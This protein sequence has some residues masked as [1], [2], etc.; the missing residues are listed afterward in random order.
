[1]PNIEYFRTDN[2]LNIYIKEKDK[3]IMI[4]RV[5]KV[6]PSPKGKIMSYDDG[7]F[8]YREDNNDIVYIEQG[9]AVTY[10]IIK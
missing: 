4:K 8:C 6:F 2:D 1:M 3:S 9:L 5:T 10:P 7:M